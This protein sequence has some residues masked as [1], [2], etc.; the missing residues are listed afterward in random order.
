MKRTWFLIA[1]VLL[2][3]LALTVVFLRH[4]TTGDAS[5]SALRPGGGEYYT[6]PMHPSVI[7]YKPGACPV[8][9]MALVK[10]TGLDRKGSGEAPEAGD[11]LVTGEQRVQ[12]NITTAAVRRVSFSAPVSASGVVAFAEPGQSIVAARGRGRIERLFVSRTGAV[13]RKGEPLIAL[14]SPDIVSAQEEYLIALALPGDTTREQLVTASGKRLT[15]RFG[16]T[17]S[18]VSSLA[19]AH[20]IQSPVVYTSP[21]TGTVIRKGVVEGQYVEEG[22]TLFE[23]ADLSRVWVVASVPEQAAQSVSAGESAE[24]TLEA[25]PGVTFRGRVVFVEPVIDAESRTLRVRTELANP[26][27]KLK[28][29]MYAK[30]MLQPAP[31]EVLVV[32]ATAVLF[33]GRRPLVWVESAPGRFSPH[34]VHVGETSGGFIEI[35]SGVEEGDMVAGTGGF[36]IDSES[37]L[38]NPARG[39]HFG[40]HM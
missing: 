2:F 9:G 6:C 24:V 18:Q 1:A 20:V 25:Y 19:R 5:P 28:P 22:A 21:M 14:Y 27:G 17:E 3:A 26:G 12:A 11:V 31:R 16:L 40:H 38:A 36:L 7:A 8:C 23:L 34:V 32:P 35:L 13:V 37:Q 39:E 29:N 30:V 33:T 4:G 15:E 10:K